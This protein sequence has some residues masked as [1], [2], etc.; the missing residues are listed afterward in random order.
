MLLH[1]GLK[2]PS[3]ESS[4]VRED[5]STPK[6]THSHVSL[7]EG[8]TPSASGTTTPTTAGMLDD[9]RKSKS[10]LGFVPFGDFLRSRYPST[11]QPSDKRN[12]STGVVSEDVVE[13]VD[14]DEDDR[15][16]IHGISLDKNDKFPE[17]AAKGDGNS[18]GTFV[19]S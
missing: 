8:V 11:G 12:G 13:I 19:L 9:S 3:R 7:I 10:F 4:P 1:S 15:T 6:A 14:P 18:T 5:I 2:T 17:E 16:T